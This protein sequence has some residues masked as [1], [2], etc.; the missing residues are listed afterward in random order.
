MRVLWKNAHDRRLEGL[1]DD[2]DS[3]EATRSAKDFGSPG[4]CFWISPS[5]ACRRPPS[6]STPSL[7]IPRGFGHL[8]CNRRAHGREPGAI[9]RW[10]PGCPCP[11]GS[12][13]AQTAM[14]RW[15]STRFSPRGIPLV[16]FGDPGRCPGDAGHDGNDRSSPVLRGELGSELHVC[17][18][19]SRGGTAEYSGLADA[20]NGGLQPWQQRSDLIAAAGGDRCR[21][22]GRGWAARNLRR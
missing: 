20:L 14:C 2:P 12:K 5:C 10:L 3:T 6:F 15:Q 18:R 19:A 4:D 17:P 21:V 8:G 13:T 1:I 7:G 16:R 22:S 11:S 9:A